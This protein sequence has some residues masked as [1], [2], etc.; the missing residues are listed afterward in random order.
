MA[1][2]DTLGLT[3]PTKED[4]EIR[5]NGELY[6]VG[7]G[8]VKSFPEFLAFH[9]AKHLSDKMLSVEIEKIRKAH[10]DNPYRPQVGQLM[11]YDNAKRRIALFDIFGNK[12]K[13]E[14]C[15][16]SYPFKSFIG[17]MKDYDEHVTKA[18]EKDMKSEQSSQVAQAK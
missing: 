5:F 11:I 17:E 15:I 14:A 12:E 9:V 6:R 3:N 10:S 13:V 8:E 2:L 1:E 16:A 7:A 4:F 18:M